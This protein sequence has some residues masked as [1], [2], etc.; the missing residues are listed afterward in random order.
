M[1]NLDAK[2]LKTICKKQK[3]PM[4]YLIK[5]Y[6]VC[7]KVIAVDLCNNSC[8]TREFTEND[9]GR[10]SA[11]GTGDISITESGITLLERYRYDSQLKTIEI[12]KQRTWGFVSGAL[13]TGLAWFLSTHVF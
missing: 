10:C 8:I 3:C 2:I 11:N 13:L 7:A 9:E 1:D 5:K 6:G 4:D 12:W